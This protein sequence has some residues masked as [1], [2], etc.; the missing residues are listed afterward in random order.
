MK[1]IENKATGQRF[2]IADGALYPKAA[3]REIK[4]E[5]KVKQPKVNPEPFILQQILQQFIRQIILRVLRILYKHNR[6]QILSI[7][8]Q[9]IYKL[10]HNIIMY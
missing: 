4:P 5:Q 2:E 7:Q 1:I 6:F 9:R 3:Y 8:I 10:L